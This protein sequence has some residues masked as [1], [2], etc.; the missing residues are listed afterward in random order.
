MAQDLRELDQW[1]T[2][3][4]WPHV[5]CPACGDGTLMVEAIHGLA[6]AAS[7]RARSHPDW[8]PTSIDGCFHGA[9][10]CALPSCG[11]VIVII[12]DYS[13][14]VDFDDDG[15]WNYADFFRLRAAR[16]AL[17]IMRIPPKT[18][19]SVRQAIEQASAVIWSDPSSAGNRLRTAID[20]VLTQQ[21]VRRYVQSKVGKRVRL[22]T[23][24][25]IEDLQ[26]KNAEVS[27]TLMAVKWI[28]NEGSHE[29]GLSVTD[30][31][32]GANLLAHGLRLLYDT[33]HK[34]L[35]RKVRDIN[36][37]KGLPRKRER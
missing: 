15:Q 11:E 24:Q 31:L 10:R 29:Q 18:P 5:A 16:P 6:S 9:L 13:V 37:R 35:A 17:S 8:E 7:A 2:K 12:G 20:E 25:R 3:E 33:S 27:A 30:V 34:E 36:R 4:R 26:S 14:D 23:H 22:S 21:G 1:V 32:D 28:G 19:D